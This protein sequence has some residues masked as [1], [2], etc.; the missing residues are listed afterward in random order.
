MLIIGGT[1]LYQTIGARATSEQIRSASY[2][3]ACRSELRAEVD[4]ATTEVQ[5]VV[6]RGLVEVAEDDHAGLQVV[7]EDADRVL[8]AARRTAAKYADGVAL[9][10]TDPEAFVAACER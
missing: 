4:L 9:S 8:A 7:L 1:T 5:D 3:T 6:L 2:I 10:R